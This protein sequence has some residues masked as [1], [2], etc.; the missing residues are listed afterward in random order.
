MSSFITRRVAQQAL[1]RRSIHASVPRMSGGHGE[2]APG[3]HI[4]F[5]TPVFN[6]VPKVTFGV[7]LAAFMI[8]GFALPFAATAYQLAKK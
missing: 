3:W 4:P 8:G 1:G 2:V 5:N 7:K 6:K